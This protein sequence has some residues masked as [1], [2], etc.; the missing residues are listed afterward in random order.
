MQRLNI[1]SNRIRVVSELGGGG[2]V[3]KKKKKKKWMFIMTQ[4]RNLNSRVQGNN[5]IAIIFFLIGVLSFSWVSELVGKA[6]SLQFKSGSWHWVTQGHSGIYHW[7]NPVL[8]RLWDRGRC[9][10]RLWVLQAR[11]SFTHLWTVLHC[12]PPPRPPN[13]PDRT[14]CPRCRWR[15]PLHR[16][17]SGW[18]GTL[19]L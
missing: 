16:V 9:P 4:N 12:P 19:Y 13:N 10:R 11:F 14:L 2:A 8:S 3:W 17:A 15:P 6:V 5:E 1:S 18:T 7:T